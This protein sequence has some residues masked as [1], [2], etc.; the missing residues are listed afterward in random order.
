MRIHECINSHI[1]L[2]SYVCWLHSFELHSCIHVC[3]LH[4][5]IHAFI[6]VYHIH[7][8]MYSYHVYHNHIYIHSYSTMQWHYIEQSFMHSH[9]QSLNNHSW[10]THAFMWQY[11]HVMHM[12]MCDITLLLFMCA[13]VTFICTMTCAFMWQYIHAF[14]WHLFEQ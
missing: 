14:M 8:Y 7:I 3:V 11:I 1:R 4:I 6:G 2:H 5:D 10:I 9:T 12:R 13:C